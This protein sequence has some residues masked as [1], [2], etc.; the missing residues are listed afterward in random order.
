MKTSYL[1]APLVG[2]FCVDKCMFFFDILNRSPQRGNNKTESNLQDKKDEK[3]HKHKHKDRDR[4]K[5]GSS[6]RG[7]SGWFTHIYIIEVGTFLFF[8]LKYGNSISL[9]VTIQMTWVWAKSRRNF[10]LN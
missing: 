7:A 8:K 2:P 4:D 9:K 6:N 1:E 10:W 5:E 3:R